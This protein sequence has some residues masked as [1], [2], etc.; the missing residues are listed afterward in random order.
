MADPLGELQRMLDAL[1]REATP[2]VG[3]IGAFLGWWNQVTTNLGDA[4][5]RLETINASLRR[6]DVSGNG[7]GW[8]DT[9]GDSFDTRCDLAVASLAPWSAAKGQDQKTL[10][11]SLTTEVADTRNAILAAIAAIEAHN[12][13]EA[14]INGGSPDTVESR[15]ARSTALS[16]SAGFLDAAITAQQ[17]AFARFRALDEHFGK[18]GG[19]IALL[20]PN[21]AWNGPVGTTGHPTVPLPGKTPQLV[22]T[23]PGGPSA[24]GGP[25]APP[26]DPSQAA[27]DPSPTGPA[28]TPPG[29]SPG[30]E[31][32]AEPGATPSTGPELA[33]TAPT[34]TPPGTVPNLPPGLGNLPTTPGSG[35]PPLGGGGIPYPPMTLTPV[36]GAK[37]PKPGAGSGKSVIGGGGGGKLGSLGLGKHDFGVDSIGR[38]D[39]NQAPAQAARNMNSRPLPSVPQSPALPAATPAA[40]PA[41]TGASSM[42]PPMM[43][44]MSG[45]GGGNGPKPG[46]AQPVLQGRGKSPSR[47]PGVPPRLRGRSGKNDQAFK[48]PAV[49][50]RPKSAETEKLD[51]VQLL[52]EELWAV[53]Q[54]AAATPPVADR[55]R[56]RSH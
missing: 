40:G 13:N 19:D 45:T 2:A 17:A 21:V 30:E 11:D 39:T 9:A 8:L 12:A 37:G 22:P 29:E 6:G 53:E 31:P 10:T 51:T 47:L 14:V 18:V 3:L 38:A 27:T 33:G 25:A 44:P 32:G 56:S 7:E 34:L 24:P 35:V 4:G 48:T 23:G 1:D 36:G 5:D 15:V 54:P 55:T 50:R 20:P 16:N 46:T 52:D 43:P 28:A 49:S 42:P 26:A 41:P